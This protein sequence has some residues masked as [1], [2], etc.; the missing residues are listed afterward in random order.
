MQITIY[1]PDRHILYDGTM[2][3]RAGVGGGLTARI[4]IAD[5][6]AAR[7]HAVSVIC[8]CPRPSVHRAVTY[9]PLDAAHE[10]GC[11]ALLAHSSGGDLDITPLISL[12]LKAGIRVVVLS[13][14]DLPRGT[15]EFGPNAYYVCSNFVRTEICRY[16]FVTRESVFVAHYG[17]NRWNRA[18][19]FGP[20]R[21]LHRLVY[22]S[23]PSKGYAAA[24]EVARN[25]RRKDEHFS[26]YYFGGKQLWGGVEERPPAEAGFF[27]GGLIDQRRLAAEYQRSSFLIQLQT[28]PEPFGITVVESMAAGCL[29]V[30]S[31]VGAF[32]ELIQNGQNGFLIEG[33]PSQPEVLARA[34]ELIW[35]VSRNP[36][37]MQRLRKNACVTP[38]DW[39]TIAEAWEAHLRWLLYR[40]SARDL[41]SAWARCQECRSPCLVLADGYHCIACG[42]FA[43]SCAAA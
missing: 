39:Q 42:F 2:P 18:G 30:E 31:P 4:R 7:G 20:R 25:L 16:P 15:Q 37:L 43:R 5:A 6:L 8:N 29:V 26:Y 35:N 28:R 1:C 12:P 24:C 10:I 27:Y 22:T 40:D 3:D 14:V 11:D 23:H 19:I 21:D 34:A 33:D 17:V 36:L 13:G 41:E 32:Q 38:F 9:I